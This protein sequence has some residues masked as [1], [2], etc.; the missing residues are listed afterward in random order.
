LF[1]H[2]EA[3]IA[4]G[5]RISFS[6]VTTSIGG[7]AALFVGVRELNRSWVMEQHKLVSRLFWLNHQALIHVLILVKLS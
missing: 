4:T 7:G 3:E 2:A 1:N 6:P 5:R